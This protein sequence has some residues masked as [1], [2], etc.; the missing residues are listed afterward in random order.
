MPSELAALRAFW[1][2]SMIS[3][4]LVL[5]G[6]LGITQAFGSMNWAGQLAFTKVD[7]PKMSPIDKLL[8]GKQ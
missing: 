1:A 8:K 2:N 3:P 5:F 4:H 6:H 7:L